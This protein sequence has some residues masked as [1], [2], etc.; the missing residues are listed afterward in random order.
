MTTAAQ[1]ARELIEA[2]IGSPEGFLTGAENAVRRLAGPAD[3]DA[4][5]AGLIRQGEEHPETV[6]VPAR[7][8]DRHPLGF[9]KLVLLGEEPRYLLRAHLW[10]PP[11]DRRGPAA[12]A[13]PERPPGRPEGAPRRGGPERPAA[14]GHIH[15]HRFALASRILCGSLTMQVF[16]ANPYAGG[17]G[18]VMSGYRES[19][20]RE[21]GRWRLERTGPASVRQTAQ[22][23]LPRGTG[24]ALAAEVLHRVEPAP[25]GPTAT[26]FL[27][28]ALTRRGTEVYV[29]AGRPEPAPVRRRALSARE[30][31]DA[32]R[33]LRTLVR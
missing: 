3:L 12:P 21:E 16:A 26:L 11:P 4:L 8:S 10:D 31:L 2:G 32:L 7:L 5:L 6:S 19:S 9:T 28:T 17:E 20:S 1:G 29:P 30:Y 13:A 27:Q 25:D 23:C 18:M 24:Y 14:A 15:N 33:R 22:L